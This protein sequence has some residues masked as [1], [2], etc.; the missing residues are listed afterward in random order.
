M[1]IIDRIKN[2]ILTPKTEW[3]VIDGENDTLSSLLTKYV[4]PLLIIGALA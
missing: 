3:L 2:I 1:S 4:I